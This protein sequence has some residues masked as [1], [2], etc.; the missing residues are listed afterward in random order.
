MGT[1]KR[2]A[3]QRRLVHNDRVKRAA[4]YLTLIIFAGCIYL[5]YLSTILVVSRYKQSTWFNSLG[6]QEAAHLRQQSLTLF[7]FRMSSIVQNT[8]PSV[9]NNVSS[10]AEIR[11]KAPQELWPI[12]D[13][14]LATDYAMMARL[15]QQAGNSGAAA[16]HQQSA[17][18]LL[19]SLGWRD[20]SDEAVTDLADRQLRS[21]L[22]Q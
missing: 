7:A 18:D 2:L 17:K 19:R 15:E 20:V 8:S 14:R 6:T 5:G 13:L 3:D 11:S 9:Q 12:L 22:K 21:R 16:G 1:S 4:P 10:L